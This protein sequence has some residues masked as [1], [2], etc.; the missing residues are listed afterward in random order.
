MIR[1]ILITV[2]AIALIS[3]TGF[4][5]DSTWGV[6]SIPDICTFQIPSS[7]ELQK[8]TY[9]KLR[10]RLQKII[11]EID[12][13]PER[14]IA[15]PKGIN[16]FDQVAMKRYCRV[17]VETEK[18]NKGDYLKLDEPLTLSFTELKEVDNGIK[19]QTQQIFDKATANGTK[20][21]ILTWQGSKVV[22]INGVDALL[23]T[24]TRSVNEA[25][26]VLVRVYKVFNHDNL[27][28]ITI[29]YRESESNLW[30][31]DLAKVI[32][33]FKFKKR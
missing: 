3:V 5:Q 17:I 19:R 8:G 33:T 14:V 27:H 20:M 18:G 23:T 32:E 9:K 21:T 25:P 15:Q 4:A 29:S 16:D 22:R 24:Y 10:D 12:T 26:S 6:V 31:G 7:L 11:L 28:T 2:F 1:Q 13:T 30:A